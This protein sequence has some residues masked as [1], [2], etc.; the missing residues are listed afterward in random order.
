[1]HRTRLRATCRMPAAQCRRRLPQK[2][3]RQ[4]STC[5]G[6]RGLRK[7]RLHTPP[8]LRQHVSLRTAVRAVAGAAERHRA[9]ARRAGRRMGCHGRDLAAVGTVLTPSFSNGN[10]SG[11]GTTVR[12][13][14]ATQ[15]PDAIGDGNL[16]NPTA[17]A[18]FDVGAFV[19]PADNIERF[20]NA[21]VG[22]LVGPGTSTFSMT[23]G[24]N[25]RVR[26][27]S[28][29]R[30]EFAFSNLF[31]SRTSTC[32]RRWR[33]R[34]VR[35]VESR[36][37]RRSIKPDRGRFRC[38]CATGSERRVRLCG[39][40]CASAVPYCCMSTL[41]RA[42]LILLGAIWGG[43][44][45]L[46]RIAVPEFGA[47]PLIA[48][49]VGI[50][51]VFLILVLARRGGL[52]HLLRNAAGL[53][54]LGAINSAIPFSLFAYAVLSV[55]AG[56]AAVLNSTAPLFGALVAFVWLR[57]RL[58][59]IRVAGLIVGFAGVLGTGVG[60]AIVHTRRRGLG[61]TRRPHG[62]D[63]LRHF[64][65]LHEEAIE[66]S[67][68]A[69]DCDRQPHRGDRSPSPSGLGVLA[70]DPAERRGL[71]QR[72]T[73]CDFFVRGLP[74]FSTS[75]SSVVLDRRRHWR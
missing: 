3:G 45:L 62:V 68:S 29:V 74:T 39:C 21:E 65:Q 18:Y 36:A 20:G 35:S 34:P 19:R 75:G 38:R 5:S 25:I 32:R 9:R 55:T 31:K 42:E 53:S 14:T 27:A 56:F 11:T 46:M 4:R 33:S 47:I 72:G 13:F 7:C 52:D 8:S 63:P 12:G 66:R 23:L 48:A 26:N 69:G 17:D 67:R 73:A 49:R 24:K 6:R 58:A 44:F 57:E 51:A 30:L 50:A 43:S 61:R 54:V 37:P 2:T 71:G 28:H 1:M 70:G 60:A 41:D 22:T 59:P 10:P 15:R 64:R 16:S 40:S